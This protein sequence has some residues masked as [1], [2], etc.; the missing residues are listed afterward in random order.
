[1][2]KMIRKEIKIPIHYNYRGYFDN[3]IIKNKEIKKHYNK[4][5]ITS[6]YYD[7]YNLTNAKDN[8]QGIANRK[9]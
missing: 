1:M 7:D 6:I 5:I 4:R 8:I 3:W 2:K 9:K